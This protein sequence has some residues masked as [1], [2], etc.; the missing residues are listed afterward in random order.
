MKKY[1]FLCHSSEDKKFVEKLATRLT[2]DNFELFFDKWEI[3]VGDSIVEK[4]D[5]ALSKMTDLIIILSKNS[6]NSRWVKKELSSGLMKKMEDNSVKILP[7]LIEEC[8]IPIII[9]DLVYA[10]FTENEQTGYMDLIDGLQLK[11]KNLPIKELQLP[12]VTKQLLPTKRYR[13]LYNSDF[14]TDSKATMIAYALMD[15]SGAYTGNEIMYC[16]NCK[17]TIRINKGKLRP[18]VCTNCGQPIDWIGI[19][20]KVIQEC[21]ICKQEY[22][23]K[24]NYCQSH[25]PAVKLISIEVDI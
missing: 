18:L 10:D 24:F 5:S 23:A 25:Y 1:A 8:K 21:P 22:P 19:K 7:V 15:F 3:K 13:P 14:P 4:I 2:A 12:I 20:T 16:G 9:S 6:V 11:H 17:N